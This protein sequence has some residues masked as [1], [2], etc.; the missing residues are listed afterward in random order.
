MSISSP[1]PP[2]AG[3]AS[4][5]ANRGCLACRQSAEKLLRTRILIAVTSLF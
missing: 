3:W 1:E 4:G 5:V 2:Q